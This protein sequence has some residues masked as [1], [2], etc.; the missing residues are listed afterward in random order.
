MDEIYIRYWTTT[1]RE[2]IEP[3][4]TNRT[5]I[6]LEYRDIAAIDILPLVWCKG[7][8]LLSLRGNHLAN[9]DLMSLA[10]CPNLEMLKLSYNKLQA[11]D[12]T[13]L[14]QCTNLKELSLERNR[15]TSLDLSPLF[16]CPRLVDLGMDDSIELTADLMLRSVGNWP[17]VLVN[18]FYKIK[19]EVPAYLG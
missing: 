7:L 8:R 2:R 18:R 4:M 3:Y 16:E 9:L 6:S 11:I 14:G 19:W 1:G 5:E 10:S 12:L 15:F 17:D 13:P